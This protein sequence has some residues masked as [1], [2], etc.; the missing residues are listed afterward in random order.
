[1]AKKLIV[2]LAVFGVCGTALFAW[3]NTVVG[4][5]NIGLL[6][7]GLDV[8][9]ER[10]L[11]DGFLGDGTLA[12]VAEAGYIGIFFLPIY[13]YIDARARWYPWSG[14]FFADVG[15]GYGS[16]FGLI[17]TFLISPE[18]G[19]RIDIGDTDGWV[20]I[21]SVT[22]NGFMVGSGGNI[23]L[24]KINVRIGYSF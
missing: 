6:T 12:I 7:Q 2:F 10:V 20:I 5:P 4:G 14:M 9:Y 17:P 16:L 23:W 18:I 15:L 11:L 3:E 24:P 19:W 13:Y 1:M 21:P 8:E 22:L